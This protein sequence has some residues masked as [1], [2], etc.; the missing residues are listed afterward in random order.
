MSLPRF[1][2]RLRTLMIIVA[3]VAVV[4][5]IEPWLV[6]LAI[7]TVAEGGDRDHYIV[8]EAVLAWIAFHAILLIGLFCMIGLKNLT[9]TPPPPE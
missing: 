1:R 7:H 8:S 2:F 6:R 5:V 9:D 4:L 3:A